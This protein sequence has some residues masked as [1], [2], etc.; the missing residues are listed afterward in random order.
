MTVVRTHRGSRPQLQVAGDPS[1]S[2]LP[3]PRRPTAV[4]REQAGAVSDHPRSERAAASRPHSVEQDFGLQVT[5]VI[6]GACRRVIVTGP[7]DLSGAVTLAAALREATTRGVRV[8][9]DLSGVTFLAEA[10]VRVLLD[11]NRRLAACGGELILAGANLRIRRLLQLTGN[12]RLLRLEPTGVP[13]F[14]AD[15]TRGYDH[16]FGRQHR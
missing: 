3:T 12:D 7:V 15:M 1:A 9:V 6:A 13:V 10:G 14:S 5:M 16:S 8:L 11:A 2:S 4:P